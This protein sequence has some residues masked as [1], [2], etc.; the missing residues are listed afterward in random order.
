MKSKYIYSCVMET[1]KLFHL[2]SLKTIL[3][4][5]DGAS[6]N[7]SMIKATHGHSGVYTIIQRTALFQVQGI[8]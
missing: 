1:V 5:C 7:L 2:Q 3:L 4:V 8:L 6:A